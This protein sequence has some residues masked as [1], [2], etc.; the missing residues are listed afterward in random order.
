MVNLMQPVHSPSVN[1]NQLPQTNIAYAQSN[2]YKTLQA[3]HVETDVE[4]NI[5]THIDSIHKNLKIIHENF[6]D[7]KSSLTR[8]LETIEPNSQTKNNKSETPNKNDQFNKKLLGW[9]C[10]VG[11]VGF[12]PWVVG[13]FYFSKNHLNCHIDSSPSLPDY[14]TMTGIVEL[15]FI[16]LFLMIYGFGGFTRNS[17]KQTHSVGFFC[18]TIN[19][20]FGLNGIDLFLN[21][22]ES[23]ATCGQ[24]ITRYFVA[25]SIKNIVYFFIFFTGFI[26]HE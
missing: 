2:L 25:Q 19:F 6:E 22:L 17:Y 12:V 7:I 26:K 11:A 20:V 13:D 5:V 9:I 1:T 14:F 18:Y 10:F 16:L 8:S 15:V 21:H 3:N 24:F 23:F 4:Q